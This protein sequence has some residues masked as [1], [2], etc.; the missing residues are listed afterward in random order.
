[1]GEVVAG[2]IPA[3]ERGGGTVVGRSRW[4]RHRAGKKKKIPFFKK[5]PTFPLLSLFSI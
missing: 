1:M 4:R 5:K 2:V 3:T